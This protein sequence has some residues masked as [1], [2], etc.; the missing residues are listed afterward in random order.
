[1]AEMSFLGSTK[2][3]IDARTQ[4]KN[5]QIRRSCTTVRAQ[6]SWTCKLNM[7]SDLDGK[8]FGYVGP[9]SGADS[10]V[11]DERRRAVPRDRSCAD[12]YVGGVGT[13][14]RRGIGCWGQGASDQD[15]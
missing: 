13:R 12:A 5:G 15:R 1:M 10:R 8:R 3:Q 14:T 11:A 9:Y 2:F 7:E 6:T 4:G